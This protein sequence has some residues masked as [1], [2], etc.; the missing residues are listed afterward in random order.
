MAVDT[1]ALMARFPQYGQIV[2]AIEAPAATGGGIWALGADG[3]VFALDN[4]P[5]L[6]SYFTLPE[7]HR[8]DPNR[9]FA[10]IQVNSQTG[11]Y[12]L[13][14]TTGDRY[15]GLAFA[16]QKWM[17]EQKTIS[18]TAN[19]PPAG[20][21]AGSKTVDAESKVLR[22]ALDKLGLGGLFDDAWK[23]WTSM[24]ATASIEAVNGWLRDQP[25]FDRRFPALQELEN[26]GIFKTPGEYLAYEQT[27]KQK[28][29]DAGIPAD[30]YEDTDIAELMVGG[31]SIDEI[32]DA[33]DAAQTAVL[34]MPAEQRQHMQDYYGVSAGDL[35]A[36]WL[37][38]DKKGNDLVARKAKE[39]IAGIGGAVSKTRF[40]DLSLNEADQIYRSGVSGAQAAQSLDSLSGFLPE[41]AAES[42][43]G[44][45][46][47][48]E[49]A[50][51]ALPPGS[52]G[53]AAFEKR[54]A[55]R[56]AA[57]GGGG[58]AAG[59]GAGKTGLGGS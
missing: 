38:P 8:N 53:Q 41:T 29:T 47:T 33:V 45:D 2:S 16:N 56:Q 37:D 14:T 12:D 26:K 32:S 10:A 46:L 44:D 40:G 59:G 4:A 20:D 28:M 30:F 22:D 27:A 18:D 49:S 34:T 42:M 1:A 39:T 54:R 36:F 31:W 35:T 25:A 9:R 55:S 24:G 6:G 11:G 48:R 5:F 50:I 21:T 43:A 52:A 57:F 15:G 13:V 58:G 7:Q 17:A 19:K 51:G 3:G 23:Y